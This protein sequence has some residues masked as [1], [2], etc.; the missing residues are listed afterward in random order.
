MD[1][2]LKLSRKE[3]I[4]LNNIVEFYISDLEIAINKIQIPEKLLKVAKES[5]ETAQ[6]L[7]KSLI[8]LLIKDLN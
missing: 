1:R 2:Y 4:A 3:L 6:D 5:L 8:D 7:R